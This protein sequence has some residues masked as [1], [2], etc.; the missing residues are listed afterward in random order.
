MDMEIDFATRGVILRFCLVF[1]RVERIS[2]LI[3]QRLFQVGPIGRFPLVFQ[4]DKP[5]SGLILQRAVYFVSLAVCIDYALPFWDA[6]F[7]NLAK[8]LAA[9]RT[10]SG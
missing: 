3:L 2:G 10:R 1:Q 8:T 7:D 9:W 4:A 6:F 5:I